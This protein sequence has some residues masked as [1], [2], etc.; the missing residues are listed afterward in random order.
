MDVWYSR[1]S[2]SQDNILDLRS[3]I[4][5]K[6]HLFLLVIRSFISMCISFLLLMYLKQNCIIH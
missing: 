6:Q 1:I 2:D 4:I 5:L 3:L